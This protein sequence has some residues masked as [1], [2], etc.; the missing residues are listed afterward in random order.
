MRSSHCSCRF[1]TE[2]FS[3][4]TT[5]PRQFS[6]TCL[7]DQTMVTA[8]MSRCS[9]LWSHI[10]TSTQSLSTCIEQGSYMRMRFVTPILYQGIASPYAILSRC[11]LAGRSVLHHSHTCITKWQVYCSSGMCTCV[12]VPDIGWLSC[13]SNCP[14]SKWQHI[15]WWPYNQHMHKLQVYFT[16]S[17]VKLSAAQSLP[18]SL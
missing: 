12:P 5:K 18:R 17:S 7:V 6:L 13:P 8:F 11:Q 1:L 2:P 9:A 3:K 16:M 14:L 10:S 15:A 4:N